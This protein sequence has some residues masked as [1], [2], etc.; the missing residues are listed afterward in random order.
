M[1]LQLASGVLPRSCHC[2]RLLSRT[3]LP[4]ISDSRAVFGCF[5]AAVSGDGLSKKVRYKRYK[6][7][8][9]LPACDFE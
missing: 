5:E 3:P 2:K 9:H 4:E 6:S 7:P 1:K 8:S